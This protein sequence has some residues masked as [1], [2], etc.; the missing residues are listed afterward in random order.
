MR[1]RFMRLLYRCYFCTFILIG[2]SFL[3]FG[4]ISLNLLYLLRANIEAIL[5][6]GIMILREGALQQLL[7]L[8]GYS[9]ASLALYEVSFRS[10]RESSI[11]LP[12][13]SE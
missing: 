4:V 11:T 1:S 3:L 2:L 10:V 8:L 13:H 9:Y 7:E 6:H 12:H 5:T